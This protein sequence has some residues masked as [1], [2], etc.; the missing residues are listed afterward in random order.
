MNHHR[1][2]II[3]HAD[4]PVGRDPVLL[5]ARCYREIIESRSKLPQDIV[6]T[7]EVTG[8]DLT[9]YDETSST[10]RVPKR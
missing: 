8:D 1:H 9:V 2:L 10:D 4:D 3:T 7:T 6:T 5:V